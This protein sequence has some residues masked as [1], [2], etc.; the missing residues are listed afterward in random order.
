MRHVHKL[1][2]AL[3]G[4]RHKCVVLMCRFGQSLTQLALRARDLPKLVAQQF[5]RALPADEARLYLTGLHYFD[6]CGVVA[7][8][9]DGLAAKL[10]LWPF[11]PHIY[12]NLLWAQN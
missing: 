12:Q 10:A 3:D 8:H 4:K 1:A 11:R 6:I 7:H 5:L 2:A 9:L